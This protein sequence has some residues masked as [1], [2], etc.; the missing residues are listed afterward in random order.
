M[1]LIA[2]V[3][4]LSAVLH[5]VSSQTIR[6]GTSWKAANTSCGQTCVFQDSGCPVG[7]SCFA[8]LDESVCVASIPGIPA[9][10]VTTA[11]ANPVS[12]ATAGAVPTIS[13]IGGP[14]R[15]GFSGSDSTG[16]AVCK[17]GL[18]CIVVTPQIPSTIGTCQP[19]PIS[20]NTGNTTTEGSP[21]NTAN[22]AANFAISFINQ[23]PACAIPCVSSGSSTANLQDAENL[24]KV[25]TSDQLNVNLVSSCLSTQCPKA[26]ADT[27]ISLLTTNSEQLSSVCQALLS[28]PVDNPGFLIPSPSASNA[29]DSSNGGGGDSRV[30]WS[31]A[32]FLIGLA[33]GLVL[34][35]LLV[36]GLLFFFKNRKNKK[37]QAQTNVTYV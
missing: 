29:L 26:Q 25:F 16:S 13:D 18:V 35:A 1:R 10:T 5:G 8:N 36:G 23:L 20:S 24:C 12:T 21:K 2:S 19:P 27:S 33:T 15:Q 14:C 17:E 11:T 31:N 9:N 22:L 4:I 30:P 7:Q 3:L 28:T 32:L 6:C 34:L 37:P